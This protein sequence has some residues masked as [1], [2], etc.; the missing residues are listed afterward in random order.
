MSIRLAL[1]LVLAAVVSATSA[2]AQP[3]IAYASAGPALVSGIG[4]HDIAIQAGGGAE[5]LSGSIGF[6]GGLDYVYFPLAE[7]MFNGRV[8][9]SSPAAHALMPHAQVTYHFGEP[10]VLQGYDDV[11]RV[12]PFVSGGF[13]F[14]TGGGEM[15][16]LLHVTGGVDWWTTRRAGLRVEVREQWGGMLTVRGG[17]VLR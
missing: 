17:I 16:P 14:L 12:R 5:V 8:T 15:W 2:S 6:G 9:A 4:N 1:G 11:R 7:R 10:N 3:A 13:S